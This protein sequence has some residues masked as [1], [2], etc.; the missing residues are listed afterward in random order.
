MGRVELAALVDELGYLAA[1]EAAPARWAALDRLRRLFDLRFRDPDQRARPLLVVLLGGTNTGKSTL[2][3]LVLGA[4]VSAARPT[5]VA[6]RGVVIS[7]PEPWA[8]A[9]ADEAFL[10]GWRRVPWAAADDALVAVDDGPPRFFLHTRPDGP[11]AALADTPDIDSVR[12]RNEREAEDLFFVADALLFVTSEQKYADEACVEYLRRAAVF[13]KPVLA[14]LNRATADGAALHDFAGTKLP[15][16]GLDDLAGVLTLPTLTPE[17]LAAAITP[18]E[19]AP[20]PVLLLREQ[21]AGLVAAGPALAQRA[22]RG[23]ARGLADLLETALA[24]LEA[25]VAQ[26]AAWSERGELAVAGTVADYQPQVVQPDDL[27]QALLE[28]LDLLR[29]PGLDWA[30]DQLRQA[31][32]TV[33]ST[34]GDM[35]R[36]LRGEPPVDP[37]AVAA[38]ER[39]AAEMRQAEQLATALQNRL[40]QEALSLPGELLRPLLERLPDGVSAEQV[41]GWA[42]ELEAARR[43]II[44]SARD[45]IVADLERD[46]KRIRAIKGVA[47]GAAL[48]ATLS[49]TI[50]GGMPGLEDAVIAPAADALLK[51]LLD[52]LM[53]DRYRRGL[54]AEVNRQRR[55]LFA[56]WVRR[57]CLTPALDALPPCHRPGLPAELR[58]AVATL[59]QIPEE[60]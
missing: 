33:A 31:R 10:P 52:R 41:A 4:Q 9:L 36:R 53:G 27:D 47:R 44:E 13:D 57:V 1:P 35:W 19:P 50:A 21:V 7:T 40:R 26:V 18:G 37:L 23:A 8:E 24:P 39:R 43:G 14:V 32:R 34:A 49:L 5:S 46:G 25:E 28:A 29:V 56:G 45:Q 48:T 2:F 22:A 60:A 16:I 17:Q 59:H 6:T 11:A 58:A 3:N 38:D 12:R 54:E 55:E 42:D 20:A 51:A 30:Y 15:A